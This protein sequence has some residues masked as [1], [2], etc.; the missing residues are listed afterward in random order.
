[1]AGVSPRRFP[2][3]DALSW[4]LGSAPSG[5]KRASFPTS[6]PTSTA[7]SS[8]GASPPCTVTLPER[9]EPSPC[10]ANGSR[11]TSGPFATK[12]TSPLSQADGQVRALRLDRERAP[13]RRE[14]REGG[15]M[16]RHFVGRCDRL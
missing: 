1:A 12:L 10:M 16:H 4:P 11:R 7:P 5:K 6:S 15:G 13:P 3:S 8:I 2:E 9:L 14:Q